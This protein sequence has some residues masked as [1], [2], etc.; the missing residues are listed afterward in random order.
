MLFGQKA[1]R[2]DQLSHSARTEEGEKK[3]PRESEKKASNKI[4][5]GSSLLPLKPPHDDNGLDI[6]G[7]PTLHS[8]IL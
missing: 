6:E 1:Q 8:T 2:W 7:G 5:Q 4:S 3:E